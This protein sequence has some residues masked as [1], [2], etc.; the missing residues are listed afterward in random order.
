MPTETIFKK[1]EIKD[2]KALARLTEELEKRPEDK[3]EI[4]RIDIEQKLKEGKKILE[5]I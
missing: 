1:I 2:K 4:P 3:R 5:E